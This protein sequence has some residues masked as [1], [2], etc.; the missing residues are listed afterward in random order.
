[1]ATEPADPIPTAPGYDFGQMSSYLFGGSWKTDAVVVWHDGQIVFEQYANGYRPTMRHIMY[2]ASKSVGASLVAVAIGDGLMKRE[3]SI[4]KYVPAP[5]GADPALCET[6]IEHLLHMSSGL[7]WAEQYE[8]DPLT[9]NVVPMLYG[10][11]ADMGDYVAKRPRAETS[12]TNFNY[13]SGDSNLLARALRNAVAPRDMRAWAK[14]RFLDPAGL[15][16]AIF[17]NDRSGTL[18]FSSSCFMT[19]R[20]M[21]RF[22]NVYLQ[23]GAPGGKRVLPEGWVDFVRTPASSATTTLPGGGSYGAQF[24]LNAT[25][26]NASSDTFEY[27]EGP[28]DAYAAEGHWGQSITIVPSANLVIARAGND[29]SPHFKMGPMVG[30]AVAAVLAKG[31]K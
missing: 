3:D 22:G 7:K 27:E 31:A 30:H 28:A 5:P 21:A 1:M 8:S 16:G 17:E 19:P 25:S 13:S 23:N 20:D 12:G 14:E 15:S 9:S 4:C 10:H 2:S 6:T 11:V 29:R 26:P 24:W 18:V